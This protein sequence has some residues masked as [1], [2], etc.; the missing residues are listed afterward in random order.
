VTK[1]HVEVIFALPGEQ[2]VID[3]ELPHQS[4]VEDAI[5][6]SKILEKYP[7]INL[8]VN[9]TGIF[10]K[11]AKKEAVLQPD[12][13]VEIYRELIGDPKEIRRQRAKKK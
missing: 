5:T 10:G 4:T 9:K 8:D 1:M 7:D 12:D 2:V 6:E 13:R 11:A 3:V